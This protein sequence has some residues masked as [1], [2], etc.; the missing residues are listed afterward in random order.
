MNLSN[1][2]GDTTLK[3]LKTFQSLIIVTFPKVSL[4]TK[5]TVFLLLKFITISKELS[6]PC[7]IS[8]ISKFINTNIIDYF[9]YYNH[10]KHLIQ[11]IQK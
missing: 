1:S 9:S 8:N 3:L 5:M 2:N 6:V 11:I 4:M 10:R 7:L